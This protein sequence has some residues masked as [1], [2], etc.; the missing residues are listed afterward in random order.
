MSPTYFNSEIPRCCFCVV[1][2]LRVY[3]VA[4]LLC[5]DKAIRFQPYQLTLCVWTTPESCCGRLGESSRRVSVKPSLYTVVNST[6]VEDR[7]SRK[8]TSIYPDLKSQNT[9]QPLPIPSSYTLLTPAPRS[10]V[11]LTQVCDYKDQRL[12]SWR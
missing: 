8:A 5:K 1:A 3:I 11:A 12:G 2:P 4:T 7:E 10:T 6:N 9:F